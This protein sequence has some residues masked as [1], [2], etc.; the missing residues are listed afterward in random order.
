MGR[1]GA[2][3]ENGRLLVIGLSLCT[4]LG[5]ETTV[6]GAH[7]VLTEALSR[8]DQWELGVLRPISGAAPRDKKTGDLRYVPLDPDAPRLTKNGKP[9]KRRWEERGVEELSYDD[10]HHAAVALRRRLDYGPGSAPDL[11]DEERAARRGVIEGVVDAL[12]TV[13]T[14]PR[15]GST[16]AIDA[17][18][19]WAWTRGPKRVKDALQK[20]A[21]A[22]VERNDPAALDPSE[23][24]VAE[25][26]DLETGPI[27]FDDNGASA[28]QDQGAPVAAETRRRCLDAA[29]GYRTEKDGQKG[30]GF[31]FHQHTIVRVPDPGNDADGEPHLVDGFV[32]TPANADVVEASLGLIDR[33]RARHDFTRLLG[34]L[35]YTNL[36][37]G[38]WAIPLAKRGIEQVL[39]MRSDNHRFMDIDGAVLQ[40]HWLHCPAAPMDQRPIPPERASEEE[41]EEVHEKV[42]A[43]QRNWAFARKESGLG[44]CRT[45]SGFARRSTDARAV[46]LVATPVWRLHVA[47]ACQSLPRRP[48]G[49]RGSA[50]RTARSTSHPTLRTRTTSASSPS[51]STTGA[52]AGGGCSSGGASSRACSA[53]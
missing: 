20:K 31:G 5:H 51:A 27:A 8:E 37:A 25:N 30:P 18:G 32:I 21:D 35:L 36:R 47:S 1:R 42:A 6:R 22:A 46:R 4:R 13:T 53:S 12:I 2:V 50:A 24:D 34:D 52:V 45:A 48:T 26:G 29:W 15:K 9:R 38:R 7:Q 16:Y 39:A 19:Q 10:L 11:G 40:H 17:T 3:R 28:P 44:E 33:I 14:I 41:W 43:F 23:P 49:R